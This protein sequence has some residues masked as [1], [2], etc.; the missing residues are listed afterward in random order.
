MSYSSDDVEEQEK[1]KVKLSPRAL[2]AIERDIQVLIDRVGEDAEANET[3]YSAHVSK[4]YHA[5]Y[6]AR[7]EITEAIRNRA[8]EKVKA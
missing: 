4:S 6:K 3:G 1:P 8:Y 7:N 2:K 5:L